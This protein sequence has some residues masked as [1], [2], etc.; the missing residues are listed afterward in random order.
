M[1]LAGESIGAKSRVGVY[2]GRFIY[3]L[4]GAISQKMTIFISAAVRTPNPTRLIWISSSDM[5]FGMSVV[6]ARRE[7][8]PL[9]VNKMRTEEFN[10]KENHCPFFVKKFNQ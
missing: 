1:A 7:E 3:G 9:D 2:K 6:G 8:M 5:P 10:L 4:H